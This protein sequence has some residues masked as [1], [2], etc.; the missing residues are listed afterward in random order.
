ML[1]WND[2]YATGFDTIDGQH[3]ELFKMVNS[4]EAGIKSG[5]AGHAFADTLKFLGDY[6]Q[7]HFAH[8]EDCMHRVKCPNA[9]QNKDAHGEFLAVYG[10]FV[11]RFKAEGFSDAL[12][13]ELCSTAQKWLV[14]HICSVDNRLKFCKPAALA[15]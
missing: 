2:R 3:Q 5:E 13:K 9:Q 12:A 15:A 8:E 14:K 7:K 6:V 10:K 1:E 11:D 4:L